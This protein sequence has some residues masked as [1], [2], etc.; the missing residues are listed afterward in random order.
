[1]ELVERKVVSEAH[2]RVLVANSS[3][4]PRQLA[5]DEPAYDL[6]EGVY[7]EGPLKLSAIAVYIV[8]NGSSPAKATT[9]G[10]VSI[11]G[12]CYGLTTAHAF[13]DVGSSHQEDDSGLEF[14]LYGRPDDSSDEEDYL[15]EL[16]SKGW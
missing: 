4:M 12:Q 10:I 2:P 9:G 13:R 3:K 5:G 16:T 15:L 6:P 11:Q 1:M 14:G 8:Q 7:A